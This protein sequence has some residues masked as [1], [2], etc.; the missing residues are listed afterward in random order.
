MALSDRRIQDDLSAREARE[1]LD[2]ALSR[3][4]PKERLVIVLLTLE[5]KSVQEAALLTGWSEGNVKVRLLLGAKR[6]PSA[7]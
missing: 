6:A 2:R 4:K 7:G 3:L 5:E 1:W